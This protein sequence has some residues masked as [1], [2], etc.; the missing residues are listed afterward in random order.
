M[1]ELEQVQA[2]VEKGIE[3]LTEHDPLG[4]FHFWFTAGILPS[5]PMPRQDE[6]SKRAYRDYYEARRLW[7]RLWNQMVRLEGGGADGH[8]ARE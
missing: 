5:S 4:R 1:T 7:E 2:R 8:G 6:E 3:W